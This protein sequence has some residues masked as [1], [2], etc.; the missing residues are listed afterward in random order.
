MLSIQPHY[1]RGLRLTLHPVHL[2]LLAH[3][4]AP[5]PYYYPVFTGRQ[6]RK[7]HIAGVFCGVTTSRRPEARS[8]AW[9]SWAGERH[10]GQCKVMCGMMGPGLN[11]T[12]SLCPSLAPG[13]ASEHCL[14]RP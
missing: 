2:S 4:R 6:H 10:K 1:F 11:I 8:A 14:V 13:E 12:G 7:N 3:K 9:T 5:L